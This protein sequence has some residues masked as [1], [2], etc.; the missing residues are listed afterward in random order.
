MKLK[1]KYF[2]IWLVFSSMLMFSS[3]GEDFLEVADPL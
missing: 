1:I 3:C 2:T